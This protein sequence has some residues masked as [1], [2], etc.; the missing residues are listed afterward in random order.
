MKFLQLSFLIE[1]CDCCFFGL[2]DDSFVSYGKKILKGDNFKMDSFFSYVFKPKHKRW[3]PNSFYRNPIQ[4][5]EQSSN[6][7]PNS[8]CPTFFPI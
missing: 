7:Y 5:R 1:K 2:M 6:I 4:M 3:F 8:N